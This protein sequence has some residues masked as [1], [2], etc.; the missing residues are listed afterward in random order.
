ML[1]KENCETA[2]CKACIFY[3]AEGNDFGHCQYYPPRPQRT[4]SLE[5]CKEPFADWPLV[6]EEAF[7]G[8]FEARL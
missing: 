8:H 2:C 4:D 7:C 3:C 5:A 1:T 6:T